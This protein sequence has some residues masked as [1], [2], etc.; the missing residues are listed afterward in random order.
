MNLTIS[1]IA[2]AIATSSAAFAKNGNSEAAKGMAAAAPTGLFD[3]PG[4]SVARK[5]KGDS[6]GGWG[7]VGSG[8]L[9]TGVVAKPKR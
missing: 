1:V 6:K 4:A 8:L 9:P 3:Y 5:L 2:L 7:N